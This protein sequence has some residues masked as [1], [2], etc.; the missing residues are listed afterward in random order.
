MASKDTPKF[1]E[2]A[3]K[4]LGLGT[5]KV[6]LLK[7][8]PPFVQDIR[9]LY[10][11]S[12]EENNEMFNYFELKKIDVM[13]IGKKKALQLLSKKVSEHLTY[14]DNKKTWG[15]SEYWASP[16]QTFK[17]KKGDCNCYAV[18]ICHLARLLGFSPLE[19][20]VR[21]GD[22]NN[23]GEIEGH[24]HVIW[25]DFDT[26]EWWVVEGSYFPIRN[27]ILKMRDDPVYADMP[28]YHISN[29]ALSFSTYP[30]RLIGG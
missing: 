9:A 7:L 14:E 28:T 15:F 27:F 12:F 26:K 1:L 29:D 13:K 3:A 19:I 16:Y 10:D 30:I 6:F 24:A 11:C 25:F 4:T 5:S 20:F 23:N 18:L 8:R 17:K 21:A 2:H 22:I